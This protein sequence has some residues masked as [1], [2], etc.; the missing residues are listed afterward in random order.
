MVLNDVYF[1]LY[2]VLERSDL[3][4]EEWYEKE[5]VTIDGEK[6]EK[7]EGDELC[8]DAFGKVINDPVKGRK[9]RWYRPFLF[10]MCQEVQK[11]PDGHLDIWA[12]DHYKSTII[13]YALTIQE[14]LKNPEIT[15]CIYSYNV[16]TAQKMLSQIKNVLQG[17]QTLL[18]CFPEILFE[19]TNVATWKDQNGGVHKMEW[20]NEGFNVKRM[21]NPKEHTLECSGLVTGQKTGGHYNLLI[22]D[23]TV[24]PESVATKTQI[25]KTTSQFEMSLN[26]GSTAN[27][28][29]RMIGTRYA[30]GDTYETIIKNKTVIPRIHPC[31][32]ENGQSVLYAPHILKWKL[33]KMHGSVVA[34]QMYCD[35]QA[36][37]VFQFSMDWIPPRV[38]PKSIVL[39]NWNWYIICDPAQKVSEDA[40]NTVFW[41]VGVN[42]RGEDKTFLVADIIRDKLSLEDKQKALFDMVSRFTNSRKR[43]TV[44]Y[45]RVSMQSDIQHY[46][47]VMQQTGYMFQIL[48]AS[49]KP[50]INYGMTSGG[51]NLKYKDLRIS[52]LQPALKGKRIF[53][54]EE[55]IH[56]NW[57]GEDEDMLKSFFEQEYSYYPNSQNDDGL[58]C[59]SR[60]VDLDVGIQMVG[61]DPMDLRRRMQEKKKNTMDIFSKD[62]YQ[63]Y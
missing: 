14:I 45:E 51:S 9:W 20:S 7:G 35:P 60:I 62:A 31:V 36:N 27:M 58:D 3:W 11:E 46:Q 1:L 2:Y 41:A 24:T 4:Y 56:K 43:S 54:V 42:G 17:N 26:T 63:P 55:C 5:S 48:E 53:F 34:T 37:G 40:D 15:I 23:D 38:N 13:T 10:E 28:R 61:I 59:L 30:L 21:G 57:Q 49:G 50:K 39:D 52:A 12:R 19:N 6:V 22:Y 32:D 33:S 16:S 44:F 29:I 18:T 25:D 47:Y 8:L